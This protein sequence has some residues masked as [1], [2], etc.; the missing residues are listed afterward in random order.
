MTGH[1]AVSLLGRPYGEPVFVLDGH[2]RGK[3]NATQDIGGI[4]QDIVGKETGWFAY[5]PCFRDE[6]RLTPPSWHVLASICRS[7]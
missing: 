7:P 1:I 2:A 3:M 5:S 4:R 6:W